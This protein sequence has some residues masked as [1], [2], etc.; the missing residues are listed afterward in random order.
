M[1]LDKGARTIQWGHKSLQQMVLG[2]LDSHMQWD[3]FV[4]LTY[5]IYINEQKMDQCPKCKS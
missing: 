5:T 2:Q 1:I 3:K 4:P